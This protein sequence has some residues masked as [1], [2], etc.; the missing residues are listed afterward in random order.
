MIH[1]CFNIAS[2]NNILYNETKTQCKA[3]RPRS[4][5]QCVLTSVAL[6]TTSLKYVVEV[7]Y[8]GHFISSNLKDDSD[9]Y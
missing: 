6:G 8:L 5:T 3:F 4:Y 1:I 7:V 9:V 2:D